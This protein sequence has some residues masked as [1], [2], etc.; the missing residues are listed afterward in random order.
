M[1]RV[2]TVVRLLVT[3]ELISASKQVEA[4]NLMA[5][6]RLSRYQIDDTLTRCLLER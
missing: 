6:V 1:E 3:E 4:V 2:G 5:S